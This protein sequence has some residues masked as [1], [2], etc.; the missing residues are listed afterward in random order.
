MLQTT[1]VATSTLELLNRLQGESLLRTTR[2]VGGTALSLQIGHR[3]SDDLDLFSV[4]PIDGISIQTMLIDKYGFVPSIISENTLIGI[5]NGV[6]I[7]VIYHPFPWLENAIE[8]ESFRIA[9]LADIAAMKMH[10]IINSGKRPKDFVDIAFLSMHFS[11]N[12][13]KELLI[14][15][16]PAYDPIMADRAMVYFDDIDS[17]LVPEIK[18]IGYNFDFSRIKKRIIRMTDDPDRVYSSAPLL[19]KNI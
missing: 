3:I 10:A 18:M 9:A 19:I 11:Y 12:K 5:I 17:E 4:E 2:L 7:D 13:I 1:T 14:K 16:Y 6:K 15:R 8:D